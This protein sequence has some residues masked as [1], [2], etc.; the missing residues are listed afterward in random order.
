[1]PVS[2]TQVRLRKNL[3]DVGSS[4]D[5]DKENQPVA[6][7]SGKRAS[8]HVREVRNL[9]R[10]LQRRDSM[11]QELKNEIVQVET[12]LE[13]SFSQVGEV[14]AGN[15]HEQQIINLKQKNESMR[16]KI[17]RFPEWI[18]HAVEKTMEKASQCNVSHKGVVR[19]EMRDAVRDLI[20]MGVSRNKLYGV[21]QRVLRLGGIQLQGGL[22]KRSISRI[23]LEGMVGDE[24][25]LVEAINSAQG[26]LIL[27]YFAFILFY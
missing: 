13:A 9:K 1:M 10:K 17:A 6:S 22:S 3:D 5:S 14:Q 12:H 11:T 20:S 23:E 7:T 27:L 25:Q 8:E 2:L 4:S 18:S 16:K 24:I 19:D 26:K 21:I 15:R